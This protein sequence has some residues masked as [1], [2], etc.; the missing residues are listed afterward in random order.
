MMRNTIVKLCLM[1]QDFIYFLGNKNL[2]EF[3][4]L[5][6]GKL[7]TFLYC[8]IEYLVLTRSLEEPLPLVEARLPITYRVAEPDDLSRLEG[9]VLPSEL[10]YFRERLAHGRI[11]FLGFYQDD[12]AAY[13]WLTDEVVF[14]IDNLQ[15]RLGLG[16]AYVDDIYTLPA[17]RRQGIASTGALRRL[18]FLKERGFKRSVSIVRLD[19]APALKMNKKL[20]YKEADRLTFRRILLKRDYHY[21]EDK[22]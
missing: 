3:G 21:H 8:R 22:F 19:N 9:A 12:V 20:G 17:Y 13:G 2:A 16:D 11:C 10:A 5:T 15:L 14:E 4:R 6:I 18:Q 1:M 7:S